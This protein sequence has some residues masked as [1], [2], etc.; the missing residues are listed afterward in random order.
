MA[1]CARG[2]ISATELMAELDR[3]MRDDPDYRAER[4]KFETELA[5]RTR[6][7][8]EA[9]QPILRDLASVGVNVDLVWD[10]HKS[11]DVAS[12]AVPV[13][14]SH[15]AV[16]Y[17]ARVVDDRIGP[18]RRISPRPLDWDEGALHPNW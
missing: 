12:T 13:L 6:Q 11:P 14:L 17:P 3:R 7:A 1:K 8:R 9:E 15:L 2:A 18:E 10:L 4:E 16:D 5:E